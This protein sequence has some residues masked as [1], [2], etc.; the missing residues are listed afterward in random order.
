MAFFALVLLD[1]VRFRCA[2]LHLAWACSNSVGRLKGYR[3]ATTSQIRTSA[4]AGSGSSLLDGHQAPVS[5][6]RWFDGARIAR[7]TSAVL[8]SQFVTID[9]SSCDFL[10]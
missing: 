5:V 3:R 4:R 8:S 10:A 7:S 9:S 6:L 1:S 2:R